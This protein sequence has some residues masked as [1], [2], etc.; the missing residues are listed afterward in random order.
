[1]VS[2]LPC[3]AGHNIGTLHCAAVQIIRGPGSVCCSASRCNEFP[4]S[5]LGSRPPGGGRAILHYISSLQCKARCLITRAAP[6]GAYNNVL[7]RSICLIPVAHRGR[8]Q[9]NGDEYGRLPP[10]KRP[11]YKTGRTYLRSSRDKAHRGK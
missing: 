1:M 11:V 2:V 7:L 4:P 10:A 6:C 9:N 8:I 5:V 3:L